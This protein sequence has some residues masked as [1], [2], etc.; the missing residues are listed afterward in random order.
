MKTNTLFE[1]GALTGKLA[2]LKFSTP[3]DAEEKAICKASTLHNGKHVHLVSM[4]TWVVGFG[5]GGSR[6]TLAT[7]KWKW[8]PDG[9]HAARFADLAQLIFWKYKLRKRRPPQPG[10]LNITLAR[11][12]KDFQNETAMV[13]LLRAQ[14]KILL[15]RGVIKPVVDGEVIRETRSKS[16]TL[17]AVSQ[18]SERIINLE[19]RLTGELA[20]LLSAV[21]AQATITKDSSAC[22]ALRLDGVQ[23]ILGELSKRC[24]SIEAQQRT[25][26]EILG[27]IASRLNTAIPAGTQYEIGVSSVQS[28]VVGSF[29]LNK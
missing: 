24:D 28:G 8:D 23:S 21:G 14:E 3:L 20:K 7:T 10:D 4:S 1:L 11:A 6:Y 26:I 27:K 16:K 29:R 12:M 22:A 5:L 18:S 17:L 19:T 25:I 13:N 9:E 2:E 15:D